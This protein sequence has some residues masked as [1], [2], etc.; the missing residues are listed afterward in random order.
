MGSGGDMAGAYGMQPQH[1]VASSS[2]TMGSG[3]ASFTPNSRHSQTHSKGGL[4]SGGPSPMYTPTGAGMGS[5]SQPGSWDWQTQQ[6]QYAL[7]SQQGKGSAAGAAGMYG[8]PSA[9]TMYSA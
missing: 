1:S 8:A 4:A 6:Q 9:D 3:Y 2:G 5:M 7:Y